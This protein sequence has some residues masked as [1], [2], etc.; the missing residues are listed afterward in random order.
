[1]PD[2]KNLLDTLAGERLPA[3]PSSE[4]AEP[5]EPTEVSTVEERGKSP[6]EV[7]QPREARLPAS[8]EP[9]TPPAKTQEKTY[10][11]RGI[12]YTLAELEKAGLLE[13]LVTTH[14]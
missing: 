8:E 6:D 5:V 7:V 10:E 2:E 1:M 13:D 12:K 3:L 4:P 9:A 14:G 11:I